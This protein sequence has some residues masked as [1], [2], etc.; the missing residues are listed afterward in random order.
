[1]RLKRLHEALIGGYGGDASA[2]WGSWLARNSEEGF[3]AVDLGD[4]TVCWQVLNGDMQSLRL[5][6]RGLTNK[7]L[8]LVAT[9]CM[10]RP[11]KFDPDNIIY[12]AK[13]AR[14]DDECM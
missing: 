6:D 4:G 10:G 1:M 14:G 5:F 2:E 8:H 3:N 7:E 11:P 12:T 9:K 13:T